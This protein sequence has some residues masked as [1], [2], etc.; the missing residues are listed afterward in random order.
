MWCRTAGRHSCGPQRHLVRTWAGWEAGQSQSVAWSFWAMQAE[1]TGQYFFYVIGHD[2]LAS[3]QVAVAVVGCIFNIVM[4]YIAYRG[5]DAA[6]WLQTVLVILQ[7]IV[8]TLL[9][10]TTFYSV[11]VSHDQLDSITPEWSW[12]SPVGLSFNDFM[13]GVL[14]CLFIYWGWDAVLNINEETKDPAKTPGRAALLATVILLAG[15]LIVTTATVAYAGL[16]DSGIGLNNPTVQENVFAAM[17]LPLTGSWGTVFILIVT[18]LSTAASAQTTILPT[19][20]GTLS[21]AVYKALPAR[22]A[23]VHPKYM[24]PGFATFMTCGIG[25][26]YYIGMSIISTSLLQDT[27]LSI[28]LAIAFYYGLTGF[29]CVWYFRKESFSSIRAFFFKFMLPLIGGSMLAFA[30]V[31]SAIQMLSPDYSGT[32]YFGVGGVF[33][34]GIGS[35]VVGVVIMFL[36]Q[37]KQPGFFRGETLRKDTPVLVPD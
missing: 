35:L 4:A 13:Q 17:S 7:Y 9:A 30:F 28:S 36:W 19:A 8:L 22:F 14:L 32:S 6:T 25:L 27:I 5:L 1:I 11:F 29:A 24:T 16:G 31:A 34:I 33:V 15:Y 2:S 21:M 18:L 12:F 3:N 23:K 20:R 37:F 10:V 26:A